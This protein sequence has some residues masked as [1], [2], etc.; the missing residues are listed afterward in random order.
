M[1]AIELLRVIQKF[2]EKYPDVD[3]SNRGIYIDTEVQYGYLSS[4]EI[5][6]E[7]IKFKTDKWSDNEIVIPELK[8]ILEKSKS[9]KIHI[10]LGNEIITEIPHLIKAY[11][12]CYFPEFTVE[13][14]QRHVHREEI[15]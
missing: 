5:G 3:L 12:L 14:N 8:S 2:E 11:S 1:Y 7:Y 4:Y 15:L 6:L 10:E 13:E 9:K